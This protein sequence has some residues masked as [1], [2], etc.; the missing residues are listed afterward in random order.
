MKASKIARLFGAL[1]FLTLCSCEERS[2]DGLA[3]D[4][5]YFPGCDVDGNQIIQVDLEFLNNSSNPIDIYFPPAWGLYGGL[6]FL[7]FD[8]NKKP[9]KLLNYYHGMP[10]PIDITDY[11][12]VTWRIP[13]KG[14]VL[15][16]KIEPIYDE[17][18]DPNAIQYAKVQYWSPIPVGVFRSKSDFWNRKKPIESEYSKVHLL[19]CHDFPRTAG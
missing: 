14:H 12:D 16:T 10:T 19:T 1:V 9:L 11:E 17:Y 5:R 8:E 18:K 3:I 4:A 13:P 6:K 2:S 15:L 7:A